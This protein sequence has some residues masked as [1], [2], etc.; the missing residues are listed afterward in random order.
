MLHCLVSDFEMSP[1]PLWFLLFIK[2]KFVVALLN[3]ADYLAYQEALFQDE[4][5]PFNHQ[6]YAR[7]IDNGENPPNVTSSAS[8]DISQQKVDHCHF[9][10]DW[11]YFSSAVALAGNGVGPTTTKGLSMN[12]WENSAT[13][14]TNVLWSEPSKMDMTLTASLWPSTNSIL[15]KETA[16]S[17]GEGDKRDELDQGPGD[18]SMVGTLRDDTLVESGSVEKVV[19]AHDGWNGTTDESSGSGNGSG[20][21]SSGSSSSITNESNESSS[22][23]DAMYETFDDVSDLTEESD[24]NDDDES[25][26]GATFEMFDD[27][28]VLTEES[29]LWGDDDDGNLTMEEDSSFVVENGTTFDMSFLKQP[30]SASENA[31]MLASALQDSNLFDFLGK[32]CS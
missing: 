4:N 10:T 28:S 12:P 20:G 3:I 16:M 15:G 27:V 14:S 22:C 29:G 8:F 17:L 19:F 21:G 31:S 24:L 25:I 7:G 26:E 1:P 30:D 23:D 18:R 2:Q 9:L 11:F 6:V 13:S 5:T 32:I